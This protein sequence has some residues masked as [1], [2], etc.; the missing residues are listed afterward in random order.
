MRWRG[1]KRGGCVF[2]KEEKR[3][4]AVHREERWEKKVGAEVDAEKRGV[5]GR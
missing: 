4:E 5:R 1:E 2:K 3:E